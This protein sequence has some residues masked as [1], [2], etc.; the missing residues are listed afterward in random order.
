MKKKG[1]IEMETVLVTG[2][3]GFIGSNLVK[4]LLFEYR[5][6]V[7][8][9]LSMGSLSNLPDSPNLF[10]IKGSITDE[11]LIVSIFEN[12]CFSYV[13][14]LAAVASVADSIER[15]LYCN[16]VNMRATVR[17]LEEAKQ[18][19]DK[20]KRFFFASSAAVYGDEPTVPK[21]ENATILPLSPYAIDKFAAEK[22]VVNYYNLFGLKT[23]C[24]RFFN[25]FGTHQNPNSPY[26]GVISIIND[27]FERA[28]K[29]K[30]VQFTIYGDGYQ[31]RDF[32]Y[33]DD[34]IEAIQLIVKSD[35]S[36]GNVYN[37]G[38][39]KETTLNNLISIYEE[40]TGAKINIVNA[41]E[42]KGDIK[43]SLANID[44]LSK[45]GYVIHETVASGIAKY[46]KE[47]HR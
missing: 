36:L 9:D 42:R 32:V 47:K 28:E 45:L 44:E 34:L 37:I 22:Y 25:V 18:Q 10:F 12:E 1:E 6:V 39:G 4:K 46:W 11:N 13:Y 27:C 35:E 3:A 31:S 7:I 24:A 19:K 21:S 2:G 40:V 41:R 8:D 43:R 30:D 29:V 20:I 5:V 26:S 23:S 33:I 16:E 15:T 17:L 14:H 38:T